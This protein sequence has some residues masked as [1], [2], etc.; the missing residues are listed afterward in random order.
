MSSDSPTGSIRNEDVHVP[1]ADLLRN[2]IDD[3]VEAIERGKY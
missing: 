1:D 2:V 3:V